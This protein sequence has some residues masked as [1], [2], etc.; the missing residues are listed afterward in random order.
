MSFTKC[1]CP[2][3]SH[4]KGFKIVFYNI[5]SFL[6]LKQEIFVILCSES[7]PRDTENDLETIQNRTSF[8]KR[9][10]TIN[11][12]FH[13]SYNDL[14]GAMIAIIYYICHATFVLFLYFVTGRVAE[15]MC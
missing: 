6:L 8:H 12:E 13:F 3:L 15:I 2:K 9:R 10:V 14:A 7:V 5:L 4:L 1:I 11:Y